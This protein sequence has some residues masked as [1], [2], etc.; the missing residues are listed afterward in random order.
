[1]YYLQ[2]LPDNPKILDSLAKERNFAYYQLGV[3]YKEKFKEYQRAADKLETL[4]VSG[5]EERLVLPSMYHLYK[6][7]QIIDQPQADAMK[8][9]IITMYPDSRYAE[10]LS[11]SG[12]D[13]I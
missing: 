1:G 4:L 10:I 6:I 7:Y 12:A 3:I 8:Q 2:T 9:Q 13:N 5:P 11:S